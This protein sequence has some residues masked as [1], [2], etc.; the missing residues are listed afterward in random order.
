MGIPVRERDVSVGEIHIPVC[1]RSIPVGERGIHVHERV[2]TLLHCFM[3]DIS[4][5]SPITHSDT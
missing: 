2:H 3:Y 5:N 1:G 4:R